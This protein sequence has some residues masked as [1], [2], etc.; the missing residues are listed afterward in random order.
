MCKCEGCKNME[1][2]NSHH[3]KGPHGTMSS[4]KCELSSQISFSGSKRSKMYEEEEDE[5]D[6]DHGDYKKYS[7]PRKQISSNMNQIHINELQKS[8]KK[9]HS[10]SSATIELLS[11]RI[12][13]HDEHDM[14][15]EKKY[16]Y[17]TPAEQKKGTYRDYTPSPDRGVA[18]EGRQ[19]RNVRPFSH[20]NQDEYEINKQGTC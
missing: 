14:D 17:K 8:N 6:T 18:Y 4:E 15:S 3:K 7:H 19:R 2:T 1:Y 16:K 20:L 12:K 5:E 13:H 10:T 11:D 9:K